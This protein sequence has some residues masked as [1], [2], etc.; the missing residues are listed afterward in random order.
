MA[1]KSK[2]EQAQEDQQDELESQSAE[3]AVVLD[4]ALDER[5]HGDLAP[6]YGDYDKPEELDQSEMVHSEGTIEVGVGEDKVSQTNDV[7]EER[8]RI[9]H[10]IDG[11]EEVLQAA[12]LFNPVTGTAEVP[13]V[14]Y[15]F[16]LAENDNVDPIET[17]G[18]QDQKDRNRRA[19]G[20][21]DPELNDSR[22]EKYPNRSLTARSK[23][24]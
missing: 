21:I 7:D 10:K 22:R 17:D 16:D 15:G 23:R 20:V 12:T 5:P 4:E 14:E 8:G 9:A 6:L 19:V 11:T 3:D 1:K 2:A 24:S 18:I 13:P